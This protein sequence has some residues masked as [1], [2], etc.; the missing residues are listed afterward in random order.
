[1]IKVSITG[2]DYANKA[3]VYV[4]DKLCGTL[5]ANVEKKKV[6]DFYCDHVGNH[7]KIISARDD[8]SL[9]LF[10]VSVYTAT[11]KQLVKPFIYDIS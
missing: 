4:G 11:I 6:Y 3:K 9:K 8:G 7:I 2:D 5:P 10:N 1:M